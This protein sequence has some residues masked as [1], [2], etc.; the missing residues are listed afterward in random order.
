LYTQPIRNPT[1]YHLSGLASGGYLTSVKYARKRDGLLNTL[2][3]VHKVSAN[4][5]V[6]VVTV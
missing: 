4:I 2:K 1:Y 6:F 5:M 3:Y